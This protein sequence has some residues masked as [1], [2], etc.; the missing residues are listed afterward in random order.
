MQRTITAASAVI[1]LAGWAGAQT[2]SFFYHVQASPPWLNAGQTGTVTI[3]CSFSP[4]I[5]QL[6]STPLGP[7]PVLGLSAGAFDIVASGGALTHPALIEPYTVG[8]PG[9]PLGSTVLGVAWSNG[10]APPIGTVSTLTPTPIWTVTY[11]HGVGNAVVNC[12]PTGAHSVW[13]GNPG[14]PAI[15]VFGTQVLGASWV[16]LSVPTPAGLALFAAAATL[17]PR[18]RRHGSYPER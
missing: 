16:Y 5:G 7:R 3:L 9:T 6:V 18:R 4:G 2:P 12:N 11:T 17:A 14:E 10:A 1:S 8:S 15:E 13:A